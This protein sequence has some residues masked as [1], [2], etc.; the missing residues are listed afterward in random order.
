MIWADSHWV[1]LAINLD[2]GLVEVL[3][4]FPTLNSDRKV[5]RNMAPVIKSLPYLVKKVANYEPTQFRG[6]APFAWSRLGGLYIN[7][8]GGLCGHVAVEFLEMHAHGDPA[9]HLS[10]LTDSIIDAI[11][12]QYTLEIYK[13][14]V[15]PA[16]YSRCMMSKMILR[17]LT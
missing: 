5:A 17:C 11:R 3:D 2:L 13:T 1:G 10:G 16:D 12:K 4:P 7:S 8:R 14:I 15:L 9:P 6:L